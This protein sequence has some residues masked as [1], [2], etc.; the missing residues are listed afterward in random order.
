M[1]VYEEKGPLIAPQ[2]VGSPYIQDASN[3]PLIADT[4]IY[5]FSESIP[6]MEQGCMNSMNGL[7]LC[8]I[9]A[10]PLK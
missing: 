9:L 6:T 7:L 5:L 2:T 3:V 8:P 10:N 1:G 4:P